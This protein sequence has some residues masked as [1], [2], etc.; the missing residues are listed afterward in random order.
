MET[1]VFQAVMP[2]VTPRW[3]EAMMKQIVYCGL[4]LGLLLSAC[5]RNDSDKSPE[6]PMDMMDEQFKAYLLE[7]FDLDKDGTINMYEADLVKEINI[8]HHTPFIYS[9]EGIQYFKNLEKLD[10]SRA[11]ISTIDVSLNPALKTLICDNT[12]ITELDVSNNLALETLSSNGNQT[13][14][15]LKLNPELKILDISGHGMSSLDFRGNKY[16][17]ELTCSGANLLTLDVSQSD[18]SLLDCYGPTTLSYLNIDG[19][20]SLKSLSFSSSVSVDLNNCPNLEKLRVGYSLDLD[21]SPCKFLKYL[22]CINMSFNKLD[23]ANFPDLEDL[24]LSYVRGDLTGISQNMQLQT[25]H[26]ESTNLL[27]SPTEMT[28]HKKIKTITILVGII[29]IESLDFS[30][31]TELEYL[32]LYHRFTSLNVNGCTA[33]TTLICR[34]SSIMEINLKDNTSLSIFECNDGQLSELNLEECT[35]LTDLSCRSN[36]LTNLKFANHTELISLDCRSNKITDIDLTGCQSLK[37]LLCYSNLL[38]TIDLSNSPLLYNINCRYNLI[39]PSLDLS[40]CKELNTVQCNSNPNLS[41]LFIY[42]NHSIATLSKDQ[43][44]EIVLVD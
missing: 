39:Q 19:C 16:L 31:C 10:C 24:S 36:N 35:N 14:Q 29:E 2:A 4:A 20:A 26:L 11:Q 34:S 33:L 1:S 22:H 5:D 38:T 41:E 3:L 17:K 15:S 37:E 43:N 21:I 18:I 42:R 30:G 7:N 8:Y 12:N 27:F 23:L 6:I 44:T 13:L 25:L 40:Q 9:L 28:N 32:E